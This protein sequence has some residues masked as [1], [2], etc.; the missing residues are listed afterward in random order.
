[1][2]EVSLQNCSH[3][4]VLLFAANTF[5]LDKF[6]SVVEQSLKRMM[7]QFANSMISA[8]V[9]AD[10][11][12]NSHE[13]WLQGG[14]ECQILKPGATDWQKGTIKLKLVIEFHPDSSHPDQENS[15]ASLTSSASDPSLDALRQMVI[16]DH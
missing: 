1:M 4:D 14:I 9:D 15:D 16:E 3:N 6:Q 8:G 5:K 11:E 2:E 10:L 12:R 13:K 7:P